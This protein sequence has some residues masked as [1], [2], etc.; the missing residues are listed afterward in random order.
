M[1]RRGMGELEAAV[2]EALWSAE[3]G[4][5]PREVH[6]RVADDLGYTTVMTVVTR[7]WDK[8]LLRREPEGRSFRYRPTTTAADHHSDRM[9]AALAKAA[10]RS[11]VL[12]SFVSQLDESDRSLLAD[13]LD[14]EA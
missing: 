5:T 8:G 14:D 13:L 10:D 12:A 3:D 6:D 1:S 11:A 4:L 7:L 2:M 9:R